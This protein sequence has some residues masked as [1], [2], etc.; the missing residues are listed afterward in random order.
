MGNGLTCLLTIHGIGFQQ[1]PVNGTPGYADGLHE[2]LR[3]GLGDLLIDDPNRIRSRPGEAGPVYVSS[4]WP[5]GSDNEEAG[6]ERLG[7]WKPGIG[8]ID[9]SR[10]PLGSDRGISHIALVYSQLEDDAPRPGAALEAAARTALSLHQ[11]ASVR[12]ALHMVMTDVL[13]MIKPPEHDQPTPS[14]QPR[15]DF[16]PEQR[17]LLAAVYTGAGR[18]APPVKASAI[19]T[20]RHLEDDVAAYVARNDLRERVRSF[21]Q[22]ALLRLVHRDDVDQVVVNSHSHGT[23][24]AFDVLREI[25]VFSIPKVKWFITAGS[26]LRK[27]SD[28]F[29][30]G[31]E[32]GT[33]KQVPGWTNFW[34]AKDPVADPLAPPRTWR[35]GTDPAGSRN[36][37]GMYQA[38]DTNHGQL[39]ELD[40]E[41]QQVDNLTHSQGGGLQAHNYWDNEVEVVPAMVDILKHVQTGA[42]RLVR[43]ALTSAAA[44]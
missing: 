41:D 42:P 32:A 12:T 22:E 28:F 38:L 16:V 25:S 27:Y 19:S 26:P 34:D 20:I 4:S 8:G 37:A 30:W 17:H 40:I 24:V 31:T 1:P 44:P 35:P 7:T 15:S 5:P 33:I 3:Q 39:L 10:A 9:Y 6:L 23:V 29:C 18:P 14:L 36:G 21:V 13:A 2:H 11:Y 43:R